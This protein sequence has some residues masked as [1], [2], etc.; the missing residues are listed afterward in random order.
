MSDCRYIGGFGEFGENSVKI[1]LPG[2]RA[3]ALGPESCEIY[4]KSSEKVFRYRRLL[5]FCAEVVLENIV[6][7]THEF[8]STSIP[9]YAPLGLFLGM[10]P[11]T[12]AP[13][14]EYL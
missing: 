2:A 6:P 7:R 3:L 5:W 8:G 14:S 11:Y 1:G 12:V 9:R 13:L 10:S 4:H